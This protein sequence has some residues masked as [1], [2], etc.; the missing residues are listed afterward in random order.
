MHMLV[1]IAIVVVGI[2]LLLVG[3]HAAETVEN[4]FALLFAD[5]LSTT[6]RWLIVGGCIVTVAGLA[7]C[8]HQRRI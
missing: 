5:P 7:S 4:A 6:S 1:A 2:G 3:L 8:Y